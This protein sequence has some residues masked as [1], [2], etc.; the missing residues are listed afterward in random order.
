M[1]SKTAFRCEAPKLS[2]LSLTYMLDALQNR[3]YPKNILAALLKQ[4]T[5]FLNTEARYECHKCT[6][7]ILEQYVEYKKSFNIV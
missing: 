3:S 6:P 2:I 1:K 4:T 5:I 7:L